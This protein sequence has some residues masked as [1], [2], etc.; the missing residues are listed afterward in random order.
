MRDLHNSLQ[1]LNRAA[2]YYKM[3]RFPISINNI[4]KEKGYQVRNFLL[5]QQ[6][7]MFSSVPYYF[8]TDLKCNNTY[9]RNNN[10][11]IKLITC[12]EV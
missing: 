5:R 7:L 6:K 10:L 3:G 9:L 2:T 8:E 12:Y 4:L 11:F 1:D